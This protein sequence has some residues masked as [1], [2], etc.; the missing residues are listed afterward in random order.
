MICRV[1]TIA[2]PWP[3]DDFRLG[4]EI[5]ASVVVADSESW[6]DDLAAVR[7][8]LDHAAEEIAYLSIG[9]PDELTLDEVPS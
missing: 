3:D 9:L 4:L 5:V 6:R 1:F 8:L 7:E 2:R